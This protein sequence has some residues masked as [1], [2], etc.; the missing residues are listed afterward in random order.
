MVEEF[1]EAAFKLGVGE[2]SDLVRTDF[3]YHLIKVTA[4]NNDEVSAGHIL[5]IVE[6]SDIDI[7]RERDFVNQL[8]SRIESGESF[9]D[10]AYEYSH[11][12][13]SRINNGVVNVLTRDQFP[14]FF[15]P[16]LNDLSVGQVSDILEYQ[17]M[18][19]VFRD[20]NRL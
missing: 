10:L 20:T 17:N 16:T 11:D 4:K 12:E 1:E 8:V 14:S 5:I 3:G 9:A 15:A 6:E 18:F 13:N 2:V 7:D 19:Y